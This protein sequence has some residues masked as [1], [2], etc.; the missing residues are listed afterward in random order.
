MYL[1]GFVVR[2]K[3]SKKVTEREEKVQRL[4][5]KRI[6]GMIIT[7]GK[8]WLITVPDFKNNVLSK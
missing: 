5:R 6:V 2:E 4:W 3:K 1:K 7:N 8:C